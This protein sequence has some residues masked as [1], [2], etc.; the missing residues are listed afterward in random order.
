M[1]PLTLWRVSNLG[2]EAGTVAAI[3]LAREFAAFSLFSATLLELFTTE[4]PAKF[5]AAAAP[6]EGECPIDELVSAR[7]AFT[8]DP[9]LAWEGILRFRDQ[10]APFSAAREGML[11]LLWPGR[12]D[13]E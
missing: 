6:K 5:W 2:G 7:Q 8:T 10:L 11:Y 9:C 1:K 13:L 3:R 12:L 4:R